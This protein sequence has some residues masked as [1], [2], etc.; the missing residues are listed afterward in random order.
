MATLLTCNAISKQFGTRELFDGLSISFADEERVGFLGPNGAGKT[1]FLK[2]LAGLE[3]ADG[4]EVSR[5]RSA[6]ICFVP[7]EDRFVGGA[8]I[9]SVLTDAIA[10]GA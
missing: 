3:E 1:T 7:Q 6:R 5:R 4:G 10:D 2:I 9:D 8:T